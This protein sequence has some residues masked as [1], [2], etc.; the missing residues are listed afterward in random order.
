M[1]VYSNSIV[2][3]C[4]FSLNSNL[5]DLSG[6]KFLTGLS[7]GPAAAWTNLIRPPTKWIS[8][9]LVNCFNFQLSRVSS[10]VDLSKLKFEHRTTGTSY[11][12]FSLQ[13]QHR[14]PE[15]A[16][17][18]AKDPSRYLLTTRTLSWLRAIKHDFQTQIRGEGGAGGAGGGCGA[19]GGAPGAVPAGSVLP[20]K[21]WK[22]DC[23]VLDLAC[24]SGEKCAAF[25]RASWVHPGT[26][27][28]RISKLQLPASMYQSQ[29]HQNRPCTKNN[30]IRYYTVYTWPVE[31]ANFRHILS[32][33]GHKL[34]YTVIDFSNPVQTAYTFWK[35][36]MT[37][38]CDR[39]MLWWKVYTFCHMTVIWPNM[40]G[41]GIWGYMAV[42]SRY[43]TSYDGICHWQ[44]VRIPD[45]GT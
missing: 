7:I 12:L 5:L 20:Y 24:L 10:I 33:D 19:C 21:T 9:T 36:Y 28:G 13:C 45:V 4:V 23:L 34:P 8:S 26:K 44:I 41:H 17:S 29:E 3:K 38:S 42:T 35:K 6:A 16:S 40:T 14:Q 27:L 37:V 25:R 18:T 11:I 2:S 39:H 15:S 1:W 32:Y 30:S 22:N 31:N 43:M